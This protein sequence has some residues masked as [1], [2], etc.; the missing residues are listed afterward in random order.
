[1][2]RYIRFV[3]KHPIWIL[4]CFITITIGLGLGIPKL[5]FDTSISKFLPETDPEYLYYHKVKDVYG[6]VDTFVI[7]SITDTPLWTAETFADMDALLT[8][9]EAYET[10]RPAREAARL[11][12]LAQ[13]LSAGPVRITELLSRFSDDP[14]FARLIS[15]KLGAAGITGDTMDSREVRGLQQAIQAAGLLKQKEAIDDIVS[16]LNIEDVSGEDDTLETVRLIETDSAGNRILPRTPDDFDAFKQKLKR[17]PAFNR[18]IYAMDANGNISDFGFIIRF[19]EISDSDPIAREILQI[20]DT[21]KTRLEILPQGQPLVYVW[22]N[23]Y[24]Q[25]DLARLVPLV[26]LVTMFIFFLNFRS[27]RGVLLP[28]STLL[29]GTCWILGLMGHLGVAI[30]TVGISIPILMIAVGSSYGIHI[31][32][33]YYADFDYITRQGEFEGLRHSMN[34]ISITVL[35]TG[36]TTFVAFLTLAS[37]RLSVIREWGIFSAI[38]IAFA[39]WISASVIP[40]G[41]VL[42]SHKKDRYL[43]NRKKTSGSPFMDR[44][45]RGVS[46]LSIRHYKPTMLAV[47]LIMAVCLVGLFKIRVETELLSYFRADNPIRT[48][49]VDI[50]KKFGGRWGFNI[51]L[52]SGKPDGVKNPDFLNAIADLRTWLTSSGN[53]DLHIGRTDAFNDHINTMHMAMN[54]DD[55]D[56]YKVPENKWDIWDYLELFSA[57][58]ADSD[59]R[60]D[61]FEPYVNPQFQTCNVLA[62][63]CEK[64][65]KLI[66]TSG[67]KH[68]FERIRFRL[69]QTLPPDYTFKITG[70]PLMVIK[71]A[72]YIIYGQIQSLVLTLFV[73]GIV[74]LIL[75]KNLKAGLLALVPMGVGVII[76]FGVMGWFGI[77]LDIATSL[78]AAIT[79]GIGVDDTIHFLN[80]FRFY[81]KRGLDVDTAIE[82]TQLVAG[83]AI[84]FTSLALICGFSVLGIS[85]FKPLILFG[86]LMGITMIATTFGALVVLPAAIKLTGV[87]LIP[88]ASFSP[89][90]RRFMG[91]P[92][93]AFLSR[94]QGSLAAE[95]IE[96]E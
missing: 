79:I 95:S 89:N 40:A 34:H 2:D 1:M 42:M 38:G 66:G 54:N 16:P 57:E 24:M 11:E 83:K 74:V 90:R 21:Y 6:D 94:S 72:D 3:L 53:A 64:D 7:L 15:R 77:N 25:N 39:V 33:Q 36:L 8:D 46:L 43:L 75:L 51:L 69:N 80:T 70:H 62:R 49:A 50:S 35:L 44:F 52:N 76:N 31:L 22:I 32:N 86:L 9:I 20:V 78:I 23:N 63:L 71:S 26:L 30:T 19:K 47:G 14:E 84:L 10:Y 93:P 68:I 91:I 12:R 67:L 27:L 65:G 13:A 73:I 29:M 48:S 85:T 61:I 96:T 56:Y 28:S 41:L 60:A 58:D 81:R 82:R 45:I 18:G 87:Q 59:G 17:N 37:H 4:V 5:T 55:P 88:A 92:L